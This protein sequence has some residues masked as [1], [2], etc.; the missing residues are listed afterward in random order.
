MRP[1]VIFYYPG[2]FNRS[3]QGTNPYFD[4]LIAVCE[5]KGIPYRLLEEPDRGTDKPCNPKAEF[6]GGLL[7]FVLV[8]RKLL[9]LFLWKSFEKREYFIGRL[10]NR[11]TFGRFRADV[12]LTISNSMVAM[13]PGIN[14]K[15]RVYD[16]QHGVIYSSHAGYFESDGGLREGLRNPHIHFL[17]YGEGYR[18]CFDKNQENREVLQ[19]RVH[20]IGDVLADGN[21]LVPS[22]VPAPAEKRHVVF[23]LQF[24]RD[25]SAAQLSGLRK[26]LTGFLDDFARANTNPDRRVLL[27]HHPRFN[28]AI[29]LSDIGERYAFVEWADQTTAELAPAVCWHV[30]LTSTTAFEYA[31]F[32]VPTCF[33]ATPEFPQ[34]EVLFLQ[35]YGY[36]SQ[37]AGIGDALLM[38]EMDPERYAKTCAEVKA[39]HRR[40]Y[41]NFDEKMAIELLTGKHGEKGHR[42]KLPVSRYNKPNNP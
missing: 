31:A 32:G 17:V 10:F 34:G 12:Y 35:E 6:A 13:L 11:L 18:Q 40:F 25:W 7:Y 15:A 30:T 39:W 2:H 5:D 19:G 21:G 33:I 27:K 4:P 22:E 24:T 8:C 41:S 42:F 16:L 9:P 20:I 36:P 26:V 37:P 28:N 29:D 23:S 38:V 1:R 3:A 14:S